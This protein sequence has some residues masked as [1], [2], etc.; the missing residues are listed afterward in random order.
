MKVFRL[1]DL[2]SWT[3]GVSL[4]VA[5]RA[6]MAPQ[7][8]SPSP[9][10]EPGIGQPPGR[11]SVPPIAL[12]NGGRKVGASSRTGSL[13]AFGFGQFQREPTP[14]RVRGPAVFYRLPAVAV[15]GAGL[16]SATKLAPSKQG[17]E[18]YWHMLPQKE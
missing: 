3:T 9:R 10:D 1:S 12:E 5:A 4:P 17:M 7:G 8:F 14:V 6:P 2:P 13:G 11:R 15:A 18:T 16:I